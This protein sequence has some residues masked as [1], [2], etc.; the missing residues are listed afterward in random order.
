MSVTPEDLSQKSDN[1]I[2]KSMLSGPYNSDHY[3]H[4]ATTLN[5]RF[6]QR[7]SLF[8]KR[9]VFA[10]WALVTVTVVLAMSTILSL[11]KCSG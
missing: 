2:Y 11:L 7:L 3:N 9:L 1:E 5:L 6:S 4:C 8:T 10:T